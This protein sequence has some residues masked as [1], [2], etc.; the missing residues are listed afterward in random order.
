MK[1]FPPC[2][3]G[4]GMVRRAFILLLLLFWGV[5]S[6]PAREVQL[7]YRY[8]H[9]RKN[10]RMK[11]A[12]EAIN[13]GDEPQLVRY[14][15][16]C[17]GKDGKVVR[18]RRGS[19]YLPAE[20]TR[21]FRLNIYYSLKDPCY[22]VR[23]SITSSKTYARDSYGWKE[24][25]GL[26]PYLFLFVVFAIALRILQDKRFKGWF[27]E[28]KTTITLWSEFNPNI[29][30]KIDDLK[31]PVGDGT[32]TQIDH[33]LVSPFGIFVIETKN[34][35]GEI[36]G[37]EFERLWTQKI[38]RR[39]YTFQNPVGQNYR[40]I[41]ALSRYLGLDEKVFRSVVFFVGDCIFGKRMPPY[42]VNRRDRFIE[43]I[44]GFQ[45]RVLFPSQV[46]VIEKRLLELKEG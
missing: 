4:R 6:A 37:R 17:F 18:R 2:P 11:I 22:R 30:K 36:Y 33:V 14:V 24:T 28:K 1:S 34:M 31:V 38:G 25:L 15:A 39:S 7:S 16:Y 29:Y 12:G 19:L 32:T 41:K 8:E 45:K 3:C 43:Y 35:K 46:K 9:D 20:A 21:P 13:P 5:S 44:K 10:N 42:V 23:V 40:H 27:G 26:L